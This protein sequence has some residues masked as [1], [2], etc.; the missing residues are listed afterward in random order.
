VAGRDDA[1]GEALEAFLSKTLLLRECDAAVIAKVTT[2][3][4]ISEHPPGATLVRAGAAADGI[5]ILRR[6]R[7]TASLV[8]ATTGAS[9]PLE[10]INAGDHF[11][12][13]GAH[14]GARRRRPAAA[15]VRPGGGGVGG[16]PVV[17][18]QRDVPDGQEGSRGE[19][20]AHGGRGMRAVG[21]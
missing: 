12:D 9:T 10:T 20:S 16:V 1:R 13:V 6:G 19:R 7:A 11:G 15:R 5:S 14:P 17:P 18:S 21:A 4:M 2:H 3:L 8:H